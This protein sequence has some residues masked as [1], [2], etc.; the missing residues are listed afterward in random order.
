M[1]DEAKPKL[2][3]C[4][5][6]RLLRKADFQRVFE[7]GRWVGSDCVSARVAANQEGRPRLAFVTPR[8]LGCHPKRNRV[9]RV[10]RE[11]FRLNQHMLTV[12]VDAAIMPKRS[13]TD[14]RLDA[15]EPSMKTVLRRIEAK[16]GRTEGG[17]Q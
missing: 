12:G 15:V 14:Y 1:A 2:T 11:A 4:K 7:Q 13:W 16:F 9:R 10:M 6:S 17:A 5:P 8:Q 3:L